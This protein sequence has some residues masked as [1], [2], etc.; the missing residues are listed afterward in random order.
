MIYCGLS[1]C[2][3]GHKPPAVH[4]KVHYNYSHQPIPHSALLV[5]VDSN[6]VQAEGKSDQKI[7]RIVNS[8]SKVEVVDCFHMRIDDGCYYAL[9]GLGG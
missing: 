6:Y 9:V 1:A 5:P 3:T 8:D 7:Q 4:N 2:F